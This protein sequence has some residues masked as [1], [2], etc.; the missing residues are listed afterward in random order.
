MSLYSPFIANQMLSRE[1]RI[2]QRIKELRASQ[3]K[4]PLRYDHLPETKPLA[5][6]HP[7][8]FFLF[9]E[10]LQRR[11]DRATTLSNISK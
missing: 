10:E 3:G 5:F 11:F 4:N 2:G 6:L 8:R 9:A 1:E 7:D